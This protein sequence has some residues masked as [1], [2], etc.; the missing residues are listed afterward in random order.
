MNPTVRGRLAPLAGAASVVALLFAMA[1]LTAG[2]AARGG[3]PGL[4]AW[5][6]VAAVRTSGQATLSL[7]LWIRGEEAVYVEREGA[8]VVGD[9]RCIA[10]I[11]TEWR[12]TGHVVHEPADGRRCFELATDAL[13]GFVRAAEGPDFAPAEGGSDSG[14]AVFTARD[15]GSWLRTVVVDPV[16]RLPLRAEFRNGDAWTW[17]YLAPTGDG[18]PPAPK[19]TARTETYTDLTPEAAAPALGLAA[20]PPTLAGR[21]LLALFRYD[22]GERAAA[23]VGPPRVTSTYA[24]WGEPDDL[25]GT[26]QIQ[27]VVTDR[28]PPAD[29]VGADG[30]AIDALGGAVILRLEEAGRQ[31]LVSAPDRA[32]L[33]IAIRALRPSL[34]LPPDPAG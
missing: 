1:I 8:Q 27:L 11:L 15:A 28:P 10:G 21:P 12:P 9:T 23:D 30:P 3:L 5:Q 20:V 7:D 13:L 24:I 26:T 14:A 19:P 6:H 33:E 17:A 31:V 32:T 34:T 2:S 25:E 18:P 16:R 4:T 22:S 29:E